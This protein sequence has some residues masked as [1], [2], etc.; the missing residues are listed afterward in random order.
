MHHDRIELIKPHRL[1]FFINFIN[2]K[3]QLLS[4]S[5]DLLANN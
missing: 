4:K 1:F 3:K 5:T 2:K